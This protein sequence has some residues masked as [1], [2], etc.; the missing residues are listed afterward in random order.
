MHGAWNPGGWDR[1][2]GVHGHR[3]WPRGGRG[4]GD[5]WAEVLG[6]WWRGPTPRAERGTV[7]WLV[8]DA[9]ADQPR[10][11]YEIIQAIGDKSGSAYKPS[12]GVVYPTLQMLEELGH[13]RTI[14][15]DERKVYEITDEGRRELGAHQEEVAEFYEGQG[16]NGWENHA[17][18]FMQ[19]AKRVK[20]VAQLFKRAMHRG[21]VRPTT[22]RKA[23]KL[24]EE[25]LQKLEDLLTTEEL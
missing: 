20:R 24:L 17:E 18:E 7:R 16:D 14:P 13:A 6:E 15:R 2:G 8:L 23:R 12:P 10:H 1:F 11:G 5:P 22:M 3:G 21:G 9:I 19:V 25:T 4:P